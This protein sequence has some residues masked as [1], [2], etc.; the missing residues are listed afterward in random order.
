MSA[1]PRVITDLTPLFAPER[2]GQVCAGCGWSLG[3]HT[4]LRQRL[5]L[6]RE[7]YETVEA[8]CG[9]CGLVYYSPKEE[10]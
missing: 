7:H 8:R 5:Q 10:R 2:E 9:T 4:R 3:N 6:Q 1:G